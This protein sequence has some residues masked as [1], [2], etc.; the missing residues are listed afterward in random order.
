MPGKWVPLKCLSSL[1]RRSDLS[2]VTC[3]NRDA[4][5]LYTHMYKDVVTARELCDSPVGKAQPAN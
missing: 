5:I 4:G 2:N 3:M 1:R